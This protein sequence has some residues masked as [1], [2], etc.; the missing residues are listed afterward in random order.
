MA[1]LNGSVILL[2]MFAASVLGW[3]SLVVSVEYA[4]CF[5][6]LCVWSSFPEFSFFYSSSEHL[7]PFLIEIYK[8]V[9]HNVNIPFPFRCMFA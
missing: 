6:Q 1:Q 9:A 4:R 8:F 5:F 7:S 2:R 3:L